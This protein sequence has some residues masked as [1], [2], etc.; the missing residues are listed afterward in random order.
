MCS[1]EIFE[2][3]ILF[4]RIVFLF[5]VLFFSGTFARQDSL[6]VAG[7]TPEAGY[8]SWVGPRLGLTLV[9]GETADKLRD[10]YD[11]GPIISQFGWQWETRFMTVEDGM[12][13]V[14][15]FVLLVGGCEQGVFLPSLTTLIGLRSSGGAEFGLGPNVSLTG[16]GYVVAMGVTTTQ[17]QLNFPMNMSLAMN[18]KGYRISFLIGFNAVKI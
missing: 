12:T 14:T 6:Q 4:L 1:Q 7:K 10:D 9:T 18:K 16:V 15:E 3:R 5:L 13:G 11:A 8:R 17:G 2:Q